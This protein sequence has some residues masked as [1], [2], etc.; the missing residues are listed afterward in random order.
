MKL[1]DRDFNQLMKSERRIWESLKR[2][3]SLSEDEFGL[4]TSLYHDY[5][6]AVRHFLSL[7]PNNHLDPVILKDEQELDKQIKD[8]INLLNCSSNG[9]RE[10][11]NYIQK[12]R[13][14]FIVGSVLTQYRFGHHKAYV[15]PEFMLGRSYRVDYLV[16]GR[17]SGGHEFIFIEF[18]SSKGRITKKS[19]DF[20]DVIKKGISQVSD[21][22]GWIDANF[23]NLSESFNSIKNPRELLPDEF[24]KLDKSRIHYAIVAGRRS[25]YTE[26]T[27][28]LRRKEKA[29]RGITLLHYDNLIDS[30]RNLIGKDTF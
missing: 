2:R 5:P 15:F 25:D 23:Q 10:I 20:G 17:N 7:F 28:Q 8:F 18:E 29:Q 3:E 13:A 19:G 4:Y 1:S 22:D 9:E 30:S 21:W 12:T 11:L 16:I 27:Y 14:Y 26:K 24:Y 6:Q